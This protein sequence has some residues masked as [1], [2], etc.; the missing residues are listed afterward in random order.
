[1]GQ[2]VLTALAAFC[3]VSCGP[4]LLP[5]REPSDWGRSAR[6]E[7]PRSD[8]VGREP[9]WELGSRQV[10]AVA[11]EMAHPPTATSLIAEGH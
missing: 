10:G 11:S 5:P 3:W 4:A 2:Y 9:R 1:M 7:T 8:S 6:P